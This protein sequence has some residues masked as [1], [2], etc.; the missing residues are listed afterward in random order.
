M[1]T[2]VDT[3]EYKGLGEQFRL[4]QTI[5]LIRGIVAVNIIQ[6]KCYMYQFEKG[7]DIVGRMES[8]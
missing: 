4:Y 7:A 3:V 2:K 8:G 1:Q 6:P 5:H